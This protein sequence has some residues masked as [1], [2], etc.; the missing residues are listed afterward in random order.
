[1]CPPPAPSSL[2]LSSRLRV[3]WKVSL[4]SVEEFG[5]EPNITGA[6][7]LAGRAWPSDW[8]TFDELGGS[9]SVLKDPRDLWHVGDVL[10]YQDKAVQVRHAFACNFYTISL[11]RCLF[12]SFAHAHTMS[13]YTG[14]I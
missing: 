12:M 11:E 5:K 3:D 4:L 8:V 7:A 6:M 2:S 9:N 1:M 10:L 13:S 14:I